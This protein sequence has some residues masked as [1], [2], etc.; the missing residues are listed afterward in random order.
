M[1]V[2]D[3]HHHC[4][5]GPGRDQRTSPHSSQPLRRDLSLRVWNSKQ[6]AVLASA[7]R[8]ATLSSSSL[9]TRSLSWITMREFWSCTTPSQSVWVSPGPTYDV[10]EVKKMFRMCAPTCSIMCRTFLCWLFSMSSKWWIFSLRMA[11]SFSNCLAL[12]VPTQSY[13][14]TDWLMEEFI[15]SSL[16][17]NVKQFLVAFITPFHY[18]SLASI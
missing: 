14:I 5:I 13:F 11:S 6:P 3:K 9:I 1:K 12:R 17:T 16:E 7:S 18:L 4:I 8:N 15:L 2:T 10:V